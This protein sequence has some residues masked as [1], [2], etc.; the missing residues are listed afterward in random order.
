G[1][2]QQSLVV[3]AANDIQPFALRLASHIKL[4]QLH[5]APDSRLRTEER[6]LR[7]RGTRRIADG[8]ASLPQ[9]FRRE[10]A[11]EMKFTGKRRVDR[12]RFGSPSLHGER[13]RFPVAPRW[14]LRLRSR[15]CRNGGFDI[16][17]R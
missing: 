14:L 11:V 12:V 13:A 16:W 6:K 15:H 8:L 5:R 9:R 17:P 1:S 3:A 4:G 2:D 7:R 10:E